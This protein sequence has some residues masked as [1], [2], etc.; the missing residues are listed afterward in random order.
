MGTMNTMTAADRARHVS[1]HV[2]ALRCWLGCYRRR[3]RGRRG[4]LVD[5]SDR[6][7]VQGCT[8]AA[9]GGLPGQGR[10]LHAPGRVCG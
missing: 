7:G 5:H 9:R 4:V 2:V 6:A 8:K 1:H 3:E 10:R